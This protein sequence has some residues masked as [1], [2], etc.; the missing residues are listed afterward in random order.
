MPREPIRVLG[1]SVVRWLVVWVA[2]L[3]L[4]YAFCAEG[5]VVDGWAPYEPQDVDRSRYLATQDARSRAASEAGIELTA[6]TVAGNPKEDEIN[7]RTTGVVK[8][9][10]PVDEKIEGDLFHVRVAAKAA[11]GSALP[12]R[13]KVA[14]TRFSVLHPSQV[15][16]I[17]ALPEEYPKEL[18]RRLES[19]GRYLIRDATQYSVLD[20]DGPMS[21]K[22]ENREVVHRV[23]TL[24]DAQL[25]IAG[26]V[27]DAGTTS[28]SGLGE[29]IPVLGESAR[30]IEVDVYLYDGINGNLLEVR[31]HVATAHG[32]VGVDRELPFS[33]RRFFETPFGGAVETVIAAQL[34]DLTRAIECVP[35]TARVVRTEGDTV[36]VDAGATSL[37]KP[38]DVLSVS[39]L[40]PMLPILDMDSASVLGN[41]EKYAGTVTI[42]QV[43]PLFSVAHVDRKEARLSTGDYVHFRGASE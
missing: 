2:F 30:Q 14:V 35:F 36:Y 41:T 16:D 10:A 18:M 25:V 11:A 23:A 7:L 21:L 24:T 34:R 13:K 4:L 43:Q 39:R 31:R 15:P 33:S 40:E 12:Y 22:R 29:W 27:L 42:V 20:G 32:L 3:P 17:A 37:L 1:R 19:S 9:I 26:V 6:T 5:A 8:E 38:E 28:S